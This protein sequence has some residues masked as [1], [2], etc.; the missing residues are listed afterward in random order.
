MPDKAKYAKKLTSVSAT[1]FINVSRRKQA[2]LL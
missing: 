1:R 2:N